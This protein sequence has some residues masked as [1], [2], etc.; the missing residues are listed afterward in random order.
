[1]TLVNGFQDN[2]GSLSQ[3]ALVS[4]DI[5]AGRP[6]HAGREQATKSTNGVSYNNTLNE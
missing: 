5:D 2:H 1:M 3:I 4:M 6:S